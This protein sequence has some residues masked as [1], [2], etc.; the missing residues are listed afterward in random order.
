MLTVFIHN[1]STA[2]NLLKSGYGLSQSLK[3]EFGVLCYAE[4]ELQATTL[5]EIFERYFSEND[6][7]HV[8]II[9]KTHRVKLLAS[10]C[11]EHEISF[12]MIQWQ[13]NQRKQLLN[14]L[15]YC[16][17]LR[18]PY[19]FFR[20]HFPVLNLSKVLVPV[21]FLV[22]EYEKVQF[23]S[24]F[25]RFCDSEITILQANDY[26]SKAAATAEK[27]NELFGKFQLNFSQ[28]KAK[29]DSFKLDKEAVR[30][31]EEKGYGIV[32]ISASRD[33]GLDDLLFGPKE[34]HRIRQSN[35]P[36]L[37]VN[38]RGDLYTLCD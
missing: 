5:R 6:F 32:L 9:I 3:K 23:A 18:I 22:E 28:E 34:Y 10:D 36:L 12:L 2:S 30:V 14:Y 21:G 37:L 17:D 8:R 20:E 16:R 1:I 24:A 19:L 13:G 26:G 15:Q 38:P 35:I 11:E 7:E 29:S 4:N 33:Y 27:M 31:A 25:G